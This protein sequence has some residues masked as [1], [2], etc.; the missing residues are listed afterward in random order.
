MNHLKP[1]QGRGRGLSVNSI[2]DAQKQAMTN[3][4]DNLQGDLGH[5]DAKWNRIITDKSNPLELAL[6][7]LDD[8][9]VGLGH[10]YQ[11]FQQ[12][13]T[14]IGYDLQEAVNEHFQVL[15]SNVASYSIAVDSITDVQENILQLKRHVNEAGKNITV[16][17]GSLKELNDNAMGQTR[18]V[19]I[20]SS[21]ESLLQLP[22]KIEE[23]TRNSEYKE[24]QQ[25]LARGFLSAN[26][27][28][29]W[30]L[31]ALQILKQQLELQEHVLF[32]TLIE[33]IHNIIYSKKGLLISNQDILKNIGTVQDGF[34]SLEN[35]L[36]NIVNV[37]IVKHS[38]NMN[39]DFVKFLSDIKRPNITFNKNAVDVAGGEEYER[40]FYLLAVLND[41]NKIPTA[42]SILTHRAKEEIHNIILKSTE[43]VRVNHPSLL[44]MAGNVT[45]DNDFG[46]S[47]KDVLSVI[48]R[49]CFWKIFIKLLVAAQGHRVIFESV[50]ILVPSSTASASYRFDLV[51]SKLL[52]E[53]EIL[54]SR[55]L[56]NNAVVVTEGTRRR[57]TSTPAIPKR[58]N[59]Q[60]FTLQNNIK[61]SS[62]AKDHANELKAL[63][64]DIFPGITISSS[65]E[66]E[67]IYVEEES[68]EQEEPLIPASVFN[69][70][71]LLEPYLLFCRAAS[72]II[73]IQWNDKAV[74]S[75]KYFVSYMDERFFP[76]LE[77]TLTYLFE[78]RVEAN[79]PYA[80][81]N[82]E[83]NKYIFKAAMDFRSLF[84]KLLY[85]TN[86]THSFRERIS[87]AIL[88][89]LNKFYLYY[90]N[91]FE[92]LFGTSNVN[93]N[94]RIIT[95]WLAD[96]KIM[97]MEDQI[98]KGDD[99]IFSDETNALIQH[100]PD[101][102]QEDK[103]LQKE[104]MLNM[105]TVD[106]VT[107]FLGTIFWIMGWLPRL[108][109]VVDITAEDLNTVDAE[110]LRNAWSFF[111]SSDL[112]SIEKL[113]TL[114]ISMDAKTAS[115]FDDI[116]NKFL[117]LKTK[118]LSAIRFDIRARCIY[119]IGSL[120]RT[121]KVWNSD[122]GS[123]ELDEHI[124]SLIAEIKMLESKLKQQLS[125]EDKD[126]IFIGID[127]VNNRAFLSGMHSI[128]VLNNNGIKKMLRN[129]NVL[130]HACRNLLSDPSKV[131]MSDA[132]NLYSLCGYDETTLFQQIDAGHLAHCSTEDLKTILRLQFS[133]ELQRQLKRNSANPKRV[134]SMPV[135]KR[136]N[137]AMKKLEKIHEKS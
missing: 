28:D 114:K 5:V 23:H 11:N 30:S 81:E 70:K 93:V 77:M 105:I 117:L 14:R 95:S 137:D 36:Y 103:G 47:V 53:I 20:L 97:K 72:D 84:Y 24:A 110:K 134:N 119:R 83:E 64:K 7:F 115:Q 75:M 45:A 91:L 62:N 21:I 73:P 113:S 10:R 61:D 52:D 44:K 3:S 6:A 98:L 82:I 130:Q 100:C 90:A 94:R 65:T 37:D 38:A 92:S 43:E 99:A 40:L 49:K 60:I 101:F 59:S 85:V 132:L 96:K 31:K 18:M 2:S 67:S 111:E 122:V 9:S 121:T 86:T 112:T 131:D 128:P 135:N 104:D 89:L 76:Q 27:H 71:A 39:T 107:H 120:F 16:K 116:V 55:Y 58:K 46:L 29:L 33:E 123:I 129:I 108:K 1:I 80:L 17:K 35:Y 125:E 54:L 106:A 79:N 8:T 56:N 136:F 41:I 133:E 57:S 50:N 68:F 66:L 4:L 69:M 34:T 74:N 118:L 109:K 15:N 48:I 126:N 13:K 102:Y 124:T 25:L 32:N 12:L 19:E 78:M 26:I 22:E 87:H 51:W 127:V 63:L 88:E 42:M